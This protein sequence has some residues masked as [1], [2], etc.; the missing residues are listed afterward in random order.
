[1]GLVVALG[2]SGCATKTYVQEQVANAAKVQDTK[3]GEVQKQVEAARVH[4][5]T[6]TSA[7]ARRAA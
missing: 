4:C 7:A 5:T 2:V 1:M 6:I 3:I